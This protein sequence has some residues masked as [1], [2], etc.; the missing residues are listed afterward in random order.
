M[1]SSCL[2]SKSDVGTSSV[3]FPWPMFQQSAFD[4][5][6]HFS[7]KVPPEGSEAMV[8]SAFEP[9]PSRPNRK[10]KKGGLL[11]YGHGYARQAESQ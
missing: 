5:G 9:S 8:Q 2:N 10:R 1:S 11:G 4:F 3:I 7:G 6:P